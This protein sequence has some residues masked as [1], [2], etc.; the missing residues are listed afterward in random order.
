MAKTIKIGWLFPNMFNL[1]GDR[2]NIL[3]IKAEGERRHYD[4]EIEQINLDTKNF[5]PLDYDFLFCPPGEMQHFKAV[6]AFLEPYQDKLIDFIENRPMLVTG[7][8]ISLFGKLISRNDGST[9]NGLGIINIET[10]ENSAVYGDDLY[11]NCRY[12]G[13]ELE[14][15]GSQIQMMNVEINEESPFGWL[16][17]GYGNTG[18]TKFEG[19][20]SGKA[21]FTNTLGPILVGNPWLTE[22]I[23]NLIE[24]NKGWET[25]EK[26]RNNALESNSLTTKIA[27]ITKKETRL[28]KV[29]ER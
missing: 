5:N 17:Y 1:H 2:G 9:I 28:K 11:Y 26:Q 3:A 24:S 7:T 12:N 23:I 27:L 20:I 15:V 18:N 29:S 19:V 4:I 21:I 13:K 14:I 25:W 22:E 16:Q 6:V 8:T 10:T